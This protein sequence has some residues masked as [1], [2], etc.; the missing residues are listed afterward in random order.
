MSTVG[1]ATTYPD[2]QNLRIYIVSEGKQ[3]QSLIAKGEVTAFIR[4]TDVVREKTG[5]KI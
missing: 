2:L 1:Q 4:P 3:E 5:Q